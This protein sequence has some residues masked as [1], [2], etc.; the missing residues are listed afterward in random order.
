MPMDRTQ[1]DAKRPLNWIV[2]LT[3]LTLPAPF[4]WL[5]IGPKGYE[6]YGPDVP[7]IYILGGFITGKDL[8]WLPIL[9]ACIA[10]AMGILITCA[11]TLLV[12]RSAPETGMPILFLTINTLLLLVFPFWL[13]AYTEGV[14]NNSDGA[15]LTVHPH[16]GLGLY[17]VICGL[18][19]RLLFLYARS[20]VRSAPKY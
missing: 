19:F 9:Q 20:Y 4:L 7:D 11:S 18:T 14:I 2:R 16:I 6:W 3:L 17:A 15:D 10:Q 12:K 5:E 13:S 1:D 8:R